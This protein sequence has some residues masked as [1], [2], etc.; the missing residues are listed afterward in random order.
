M[1][2]VVCCGV[3]V[4]IDGG[5]WRLLLLALLLGT[6]CQDDIYVNSI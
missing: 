2:G 4:K 5:C 1:V 6:L 3:V